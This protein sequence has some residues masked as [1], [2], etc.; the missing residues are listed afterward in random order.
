MEAAHEAATLL[1]RSS[2]LGSGAL[3]IRRGDTLRPRRKAG[4]RSL[5]VAVSRPSA[6]DACSGV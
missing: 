6:L 4:P 5:T 2:W 3:S 1:P